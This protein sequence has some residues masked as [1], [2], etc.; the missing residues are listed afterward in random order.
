QSRVDV[1]MT[2][3][4][5]PTNY[6]QAN[7]VSVAGPASAAHL[8]PSSIAHNLKSYHHN[9]INHHNHHPIQTAQHHAT[10]HAG[11]HQELDPDIKERQVLEA[12]HKTLVES[13]VSSKPVS[14]A[15][16]PSSMEDQ[17]IG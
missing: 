1:P 2:T 7:G 6:G 10:V 17:R 15:A 12:I 14:L 5:V 11:E 13:F 4:S 9:N 8:Q 16:I 3:S